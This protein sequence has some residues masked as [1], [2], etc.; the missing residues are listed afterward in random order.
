MGDHSSDPCR[1]RCAARASVGPVSATARPVHLRW[2]SLGLVFL[3]GALGT[4]GR[5]VISTAVPHLGRVP[6]AVLAINVLGAF[7]LGLL[8]TRLARAGPDDGIRRDLRL[9]VGTGVLGGF[10]TYSA[11]ATDTATL[12][13]EGH[14]G[15]AAA[16]A[17]GTLLLGL[18]AAAAGTWCGARGPGSGSSR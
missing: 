14:P 11:L 3:G 4:A 16:Y 2:R 6:V 17:L 13:A 12:L 7:A 15:R 18:A 10:T 5:Y 8:L 1:T 9:V